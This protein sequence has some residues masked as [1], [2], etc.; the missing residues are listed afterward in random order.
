MPSTIKKKPKRT[1]T[2]ALTA[3]ADGDDE[4]LLFL[5]WMRRT[6]K[7]LATSRSPREAERKMKRLARRFAYLRMWRVDPPAGK[8]ST[9]RLPR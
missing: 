3:L 6:I 8:P 7:A 4:A 2:D 5:R 1:A 9:G